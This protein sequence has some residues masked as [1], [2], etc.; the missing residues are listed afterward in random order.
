MSPSTTHFKVTSSAFSHNGEI[1]TKYTCEGEN[2]SPPL[3]WKGAPEHTRSFV[4]MIVD[5]DAPD[6]ENPKTLWVHW[7]LYNISAETTLLSEHL[8][9]LPTGVKAGVNDWHKKVYGGPCPPVGRHRYFH[10]VY[11]L[12]S[13]LPDLNYPT[14]AQLEHA[15]EGHVLAQAEL[16]GTYEK[17]RPSF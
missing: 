8:E 3:E 17:V 14:R 16:I 9:R 7:I 12:D 15:M 11:A 6:P 13:Q 2:I 1:P 10:K 5:P 4:L